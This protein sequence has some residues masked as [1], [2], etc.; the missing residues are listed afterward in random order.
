MRILTV[1]LVSVLALA[2]VS[3]GGSDST[4]LTEAEL[5]WCG[6][7]DDPATFNAIWDA[8]TELEV[9]SVGN[10]MLDKA[11]IDTDVVPSELG[12]DD[13]TE[14][15]LESLTAVGEEFEASED[16]WLEYLGTE[17]GA[18]ACAAAYETVKG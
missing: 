18:T 8:S 3:C 4:E 5:A 6:N 9:D 1:V 13:L 14:A 16:M 15:E 11:G 2:A 7:V 10:F 17:D 12:V